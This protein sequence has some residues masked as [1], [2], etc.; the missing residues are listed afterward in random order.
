MVYVILYV[1][2]GIFLL[3]KVDDMDDY[4]M[5]L[6]W[7]MILEV[8]V[9]QIN[10]VK[11]E[12]CCVIFVGM[13]VLCMIESLVIGLGQVVVSS[14]DMDIFIMLGYEFCI[15]D[16]L[17]INFYLFKFMLFML[18]S[19]MSGLDVMQK[20]YVYVIVEEYCFYFYGDVCL[21]E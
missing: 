15:V 6:E 2:V 1:G 4:V 3:V 7:C 10:W 18:V 8:V 19:V 5:Y 20:V 13:M 12:R 11:V 21:L 9:V 17:M 14:W 16:V